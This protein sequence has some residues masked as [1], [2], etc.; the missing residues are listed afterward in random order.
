[1]GRFCG[2]RGR[3]HSITEKLIVKVRNKKPLLKLEV[4]I[5]I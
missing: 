1:M 5:V 2:G 3:E 4:R